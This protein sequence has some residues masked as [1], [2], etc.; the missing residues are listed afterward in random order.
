MFVFLK[1]L[2]LEDLNRF[3][4]LNKTFTLKIINGKECIKQT[5][6]FSSLKQK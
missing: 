6:V 2:A 1:T 3:Y 4:N 5:P